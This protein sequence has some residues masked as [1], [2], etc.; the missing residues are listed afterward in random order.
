MGIMPAV[1][2]N[3][4]PRSARIRSR[5]EFD[6][7]FSAGVRA[8]DAYVTLFAALSDQPCARLGIS[9]SRR[10]GNAV[11][12]NRAK[13]L[14]REAFRTLRHDWPPCTD[15]VVIPRAGVEGLTLERVTQ[16]LVSLST[17]LIR[18]LERNQPPASAQTPPERG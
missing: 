15:W 7:V 2:R 4:F 1:P 9:V 8:S 11:R 12:R 13:R 6:R 10:L 16:S 17:R 14:V 3:T 5:K 18:R